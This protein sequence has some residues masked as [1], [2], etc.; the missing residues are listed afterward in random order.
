MKYNFDLET[1]RR[2]T[3]SYKWDGAYRYFGTND[4]IPLWIADMDFKAPPEVVKALEER[5]SHGIYGYTKEESEHKEPFIKWAKKRYGYDVEEK[6]IINTPGV[7]PVICAAIQSLTEKGDGVLIQPPVYPP[8]FS[9]VK[10]ND[11]KLVINELKYEDGKYEIDFEDFEK[12]IKEENVKLF[13]LCNPQNPVGRVWSKEDLERL[14]EICKENDV[15]VVSDEIHGDIIYKGNKFTSA[16]TLS[17]DY[18]DR[19]IVATAPSKTFNIAGLYY[20][21]IIIPDDKLREKISLVFTQLNV[22]AENVF[23]IEA[24]R[25]VY[26]YGEEW[27]ES[28]IEYLDGNADFVVDFIKEKLPKI[29]AYKPESTYLMWIDFSELFDSQEKL[30][31]FLVQD[32]RLGLNDGTTFSEDYVGFMRLNIASPRSIIKEG[33]LRLESALNS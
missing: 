2:G 1:D 26:E 18:Y 23:S 21:N 25:A 32:A 33:L 6:W 12:K 27:V 10:N 5:A 9:S 17:K 11:R 3:Y 8:F 13:L 7:V 15:F 30:I 24:G 20:S 4:V 28:L 31:D 16:L 22:S 29:K 14:L 19:L